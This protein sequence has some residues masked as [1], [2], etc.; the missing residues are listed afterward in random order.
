MTAIYNQ[1]I[2]FTVILTT[3]AI[4]IL[5][6][7]KKRERNRSIPKSKLGWRGTVIYISKLLG[8][9]VLVLVLMA[10]A[11]MVYI[12][13]Q[14]TLEETRP[15]PSQVEIPPNLPFE[16]Q[17]VIFMGGDDLQMA[18]WYVPS[19]NGAVMVLLHG[20]GG[21]RLAMRWH[22]EQFTAA[23]YGVLMYDERASGESEGEYRSFG[24]EDSA[25]VGGAL[26]YL[27][28][29][30]DVNLEQIGI[31]GCSMGGQIALQGAAY[32]PQIGAV[33]ADGPASITSA[34]YSPPED[35]FSLLAMISGPILDQIYVWHLGIEKPRPMIDIIGEIGPRP[36]MLVGGGISHP[37]FGNE[38]PRVTLYASYAGDNAE[39]W[40]IP[41][42]Y[43]CDGPAKLP[44][45]YAAR[46]IRFFDEALEIKR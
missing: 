23:G 29:K 45:E 13:Y 43:H 30:K 32:Y 10:G 9:A 39:V 5:Y 20:F 4:Y 31:L 34:D 37:L 42:A 8:F 6:R 25:D 11:V 19:Q 26:S 36:I 16:V 22:A 3:I 28:T 18:G 1:G 17:E 2:I 38:E 15:A 41:E 35:F 27:N 44:G 21:N 40:M 7:I 12:D 33:W 14:T 46:M 24:W